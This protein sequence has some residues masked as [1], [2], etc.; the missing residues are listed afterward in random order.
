MKIGIHVEYLILYHHQVGPKIKDFLEQI[1]AYLRY[2]LSEHGQKT[3]LGKK[4]K[5]D[6]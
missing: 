3:F 2:N 4:L 1:I 6:I 5:C